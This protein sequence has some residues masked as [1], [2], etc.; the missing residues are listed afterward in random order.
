MPPGLPPRRVAILQSNYIPWKGYFDLIASVDEFILY[1]DVQF[2][3]N[4]WRN[5]NVI[6]TPAGLQWL[7][8]PAGQDISRRI[9]DVGIADARWRRTHW[10]TLQANYARA[11]CFA[12]A[13]AVLEPLYD[14]AE[15]QLSA[16]NRAFLEG[17][18]GFLGIGTKIAYSWDYA[19]EGDRNE[20]LVSL[21]RQTGA[22]TYVSGPAARAYLQ[23]EL[24]ARA[25]VA[26]EWFDYVGYEPY[27]QLWG[28]FAHG[29]SIVDLLFNCGAQAPRY[30]KMGAAAARGA[31]PAPAHAEDPSR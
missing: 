28:E 7:S 16:I 11:A 6:K 23:P 17:I 29:V 4:D 21:C 5:R 27:P 25:G 14:R 24:F 10:K 12:E 8:I 22:T 9:R 20:R 18:C 3:K 1:D 31:I 19:L 2:T 30:M 26:V 15:T 13:A